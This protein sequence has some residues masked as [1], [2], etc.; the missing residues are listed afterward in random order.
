MKPKKFNSVASPLLAKKVSALLLVT[1]L[2]ATAS[3]VFSETLDRAACD[4]VKDEIIARFNRDD[5]KGI[6]QLADPAFTNRISES[7][8]VKFLQ[9]NLNIGNIIG[10]AFDSTTNG[11]VI[12]KL[13]FEA[14]DL[15][16]QLA[17]T[18]A[19]KFVDF[20]L[21]ER[22]RPLL[23]VAPMVQSDNPCRTGLDQVVDTA[24]RE[25][26]R[27]PNAV[28]ISIGII[29]D[30]KEHIYNYGETRK[31]NG[32][33]P[34]SK[35]IYEIGS[36]TKT[37][38]STLL[39]HAVLE[40]KV[41]LTDDLRRYLPGNFPNLSFSNTPI[42]LKDL[43]NHTSRLPAMPENLWEQ[44]NGI[45]LC[46]EQSYDAAKCYRALKTVKLDGPPGSK[47]EYSNWGISLLG[48]VMEKIHGTNYAE[49]LH[50]YVTGPQNMTDTYFQF[51]GVD[52]N[53][54]AIPYSEN[55][56]AMPFQISGYFGPAGDIRSTP[57]NMLRYLAMQIQES[58]PA[59]KLTHVP[60]A[61]NTGLGWGVRTLNGIRDLQHNG[62]TIGSRA[63][64]SVFPDL[65]SGC[66]ILANSKVSLDRLI[67]A[68]HKTLKCPAKAE[69]K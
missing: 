21:L 61:N 9:K 41:T 68:M 58:D 11:K 35:T 39:A 31:G 40:H 46:Q 62:S 16:L 42:T 7:Q 53:R 8:L 32:N 69:S 34:N 51:I 66:V 54:M 33:L 29:Q 36:I 63:N 15:N 57:E 25:Y 59:V 38:T 55:G 30:G 10:S 3:V 28:G 19:K 22:P 17:V 18:S 2:W 56:R 27:D 43:A 44:P 12:Y 1:I 14:R 13:E 64:I 6:Y 49:L 50:R 24:M 48:E 4:A 20:G 23:A 47:F 45:P 5:F 60:T 26:F 37:F 65:H 52:T 67:T